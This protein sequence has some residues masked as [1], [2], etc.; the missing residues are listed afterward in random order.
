MAGLTP[1]TP[2]MQS[3]SCLR[4]ARAT[5]GRLAASFILAVMFAGSVQADPVLQISSGQLTGVTGID[6]GTLGIFNVK[7]ED[8]LCRSLLVGGLICGYAKT[9]GIPDDAKAA[10]LALVASIPP[11]D[12]G[13]TPLDPGLIFGCTYAAG[14]NI[15]TPTDGA[16]QG[17]VKIS[18]VYCGNIINFDE[19]IDTTSQPAF[20]WAVWSPAASVPEPSSL[21]LLGLAGVALGWSQRRR[22]IRTNA[23]VQ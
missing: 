22:R 16:S 17:T 12:L 3:F 11:I 10:S 18:V 23:R 14:C 13:S 5:F 4:R 21:A 20:V 2:P 7:F 19:S 15:I 1:F 6:L 9:F 8:G